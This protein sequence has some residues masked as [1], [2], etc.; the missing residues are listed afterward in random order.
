MSEYRSGSVTTSVTLAG[1]ER[2]TVTV[3]DSEHSRWAKEARHHELPLGA[4][5]RRTVRL[6]LE[7]EI[8]GTTT[9]TGRPKRLSAA[10][11]RCEL[12]GRGLGSSTVRR[13]FCSDVC[14]VKAWRAKQRRQRV[15][16]DA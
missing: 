16:R 5:I 10:L 15:L 7:T 4:W 8:E 9:I 6:V 3:S 12:C 14:R 1:I 13:R 11:M 2:I